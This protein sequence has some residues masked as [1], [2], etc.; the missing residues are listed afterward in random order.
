MVAE[1]APSPIAVRRRRLNLS[2]VDLS[3]RAG[4]SVSSVS[5]AERTGYLT[6]ATAAKLARALGCPV[7]ELLPAREGEEDRP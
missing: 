7:E 4:L 3:V 5:L 1:H 2:Q 6:R